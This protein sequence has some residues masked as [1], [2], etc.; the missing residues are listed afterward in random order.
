MRRF[1]PK[2]KFLDD[3]AIEATSSA[4][5]VC[6]IFEGLRPRRTRTRA[7]RRLA[8]C[9]PPLSRLPRLLPRHDPDAVAYTVGPPDSVV[10]A[11]G[12]F[13]PVVGKLPLAREVHAGRVL[14]RQRQQHFAVAAATQH[15]QNN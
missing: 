2:R 4:Y 6:V 7:R 1:S 12:Q 9:R 14:G 5:G 11:A 13:T 15:E 10:D 3:G 8:A